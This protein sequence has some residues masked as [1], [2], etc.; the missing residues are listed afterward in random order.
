MMR[1]VA[2][3]ILGYVVM[4]VLV[5]VLFSIAYLAMGSGGAF[6]PGSYD[7]SPLWIVASM[8]LGLI[9]AFVGGRVC[10]Q[11]SQNPKA[12]YALVAVVLVL[13]IGMAVPALNT[14]NHTQSLI[15]EG[16]VGNIEAMQSAKQPTWLSFVNPVI[17]A[18]GV[19]L[20]A[21]FKRA[22]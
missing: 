4:A 10:A 18:V 19:L 22:S 14:P 17:G 12:P 2:G 16:D 6:E 3:I 13:G 5:F 9:A 15:R 11:F 1:M 20:G 21:R 7:V 8:V